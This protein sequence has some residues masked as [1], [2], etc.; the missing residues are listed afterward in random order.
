MEE[1]PIEEKDHPAAHLY[2]YSFLL[3][4][5]RQCKTGSKKAGDDHYVAQLWRSDAKRHGRTD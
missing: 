3:H 4:W 5:V 2:F 1:G